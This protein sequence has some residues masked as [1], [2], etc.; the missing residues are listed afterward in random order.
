MQEDF[1]INGKVVADFS[2]ITQGLRNVERGAVVNVKVDGAQPL[3]RLTS[4]VS[5]FDKSM[6][7]A[8]ARV[9]AFGASAAVISGVSIALKAMVSNAISVEA[10]LADINSLLS[11]SSGSLNKFST[12]LFE[13]AKDTGQSFDTVAESAKEFSRQGL[14]VEQTLQRTK[15]AMIAVLNNRRRILTK[16]H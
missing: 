6:E 1:I 15:D 12:D 11:L 3:G 13:V 4:K 14:D 2:S 16:E 10:K 9:L 8:N 7:A 5:E